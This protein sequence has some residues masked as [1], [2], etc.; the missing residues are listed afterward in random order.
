MDRYVSLIGWTYC[1]QPNE[2]IGSTLSP[3]TEGARISLRVKCTGMEL[4]TKVPVT[5][6]VENVIARLKLKVQG[7]TSN[8]HL[9][10]P[11]NF[12]VLYNY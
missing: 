11:G 4:V 10:I 5:S 9:F 1:I 12:I 6:T 8:F 7:N 2:N 3:I